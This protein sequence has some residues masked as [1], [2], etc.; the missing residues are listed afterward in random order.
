MSRIG[1]KP[2]TIPA[3]VNVTIGP[4]SVTVKGAKGELAMPYDPQFKITR[5]NNIVS[6][7]RPSDVKKDKALHGLYRALI[8]NMV[9][10]VTTGFSKVLEIKG[11]G[12]RSKVVGTNL[13]LSLGYSHPVAVTIPQGINVA[14]DEKAN[15]ITISGANKHDVG[16]FAAN[17]RAYRPVEPYKG[18]GIRYAGERVIMKAGKA[19]KT[20]KK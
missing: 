10:G 9:T 4:N 3:A 16:Q 13:E 1:R 20:G 18:K 15:T 19:G 8:Q 14:I 11:V 17:V 6:V 5:E 2:V 12:Y 7:A